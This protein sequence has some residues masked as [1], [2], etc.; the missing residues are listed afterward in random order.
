MRLFSKARHAFEDIVY[1]GR[2]PVPNGLSQSTLSN[3][4]E[5]LCWAAHKETCESLDRAKGS[6]GS[7]V[8][9]LPPH[10]RRIYTLVALDADVLNGG[11][12]QFFT[13]AGGRYDSHL[14]Q[15]VEALGQSGITEIVIRAWKQYTGIDYSNQWR[16]RGKS[17][18]FFVEPY[19][20]G[21]FNAE[22]QDYYDFVDK[23]WLVPHIGRHIR[24]HFDLYSTA[25]LT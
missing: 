7:K 23:E 4:D 13:N 3:N 10:W 5:D 18:D 14:L 19:K 24:E 1:A 12:Y 15:D 22:D 8:K 21:R 11:F 2:M 20:E 17:W 9:H 25:S 6:Y 16:N